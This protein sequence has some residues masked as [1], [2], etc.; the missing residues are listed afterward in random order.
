ML[1]ALLV[2]GVTASAC[3]ASQHATPTQQMTSWVQGTPF[4][5]AVGQ[6]RSDLAKATALLASNPSAAQ[7][8]TVCGVLLIEIEA[9]NADLPTPDPTATT[10]LSGGYEAL[11]AAAHDCYDAVGD[12][13]KAAA[14]AVDKA[15]GLALLS[16]G[17]LQ[18]EAILGRPV[19]VTTTTGAHAAG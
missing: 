2:G 6:I 11:G 3:G 19:D 13:A 9:A 18:V 7:A 12:P 15:R 14:F 8:H 4:A 10:L 17:Q 1:L 5:E 16:E